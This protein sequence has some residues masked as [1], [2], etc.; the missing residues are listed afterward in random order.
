MRLIS[1]PARGRAKPKN[2]QA[3]EIGH[4]ASQHVLVFAK[5]L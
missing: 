1:M 3:G 2:D 5:A 4:G